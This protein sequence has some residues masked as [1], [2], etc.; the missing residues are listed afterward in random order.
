MAQT[1]CFAYLRLWHR[2][3]FAIDS[4]RASSLYRVFSSDKLS[5]Q[6]QPLRWTFGRRL[7]LE[8]RHGQLYFI[9]G[10]SVSD[11]TSDVY[12]DEGIWRKERGPSQDGSFRFRTP[13]GLV[14]CEVR[15]SGIWLVYYFSQMDIL[16]SD[17]DHSFLVATNAQ[18]NIWSSMVRSVADGQLSP[19]PD[20]VL[21]IDF[22]AYFYDYVIPGNVYWMT[23]ASVASLVDHLKM[24]SGPS[25]SL[26]HTYYAH[27]WL[28]EYVNSGRHLTLARFTKL[29]SAC[30]DN[31]CLSGVKLPPQ[32]FTFYTFD[33][34]LDHRC[35]YYQ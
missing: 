19:Y 16:T 27:G 17:P 30:Y 9:D 2:E 3:V 6:L 28:L 21:E 8:S 32:C 5:T 31:L 1:L 10:P 13:D 29:C 14:R 4:A 33:Q 24:S 35:V 25:H 11:R 7:K 12:C 22:V 15:F 26:L 20:V 34:L 18:E 23:H